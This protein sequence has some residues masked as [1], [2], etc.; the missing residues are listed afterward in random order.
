MIA[1]LLFPAPL[2][3][4]DEGFEI[5]GR[6][7]H[8][9]RDADVRQLAALDDVVDGSRAEAQVRSDF[10]NAEKPVSPTLN[11]PEPERARSEPSLTF[12][13]LVCANFGRYGRLWLDST[14]SGNEP[15]PNGL[16]HLA[17]QRSRWTLFVRSF[18]PWVVGSSPT[19][20]TL[21]A[22]GVT[23]DF[24]GLRRGGLRLR[25]PG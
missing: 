10:S 15:S 14:A 17:M 23:G 21:Q 2:R 6:D 1:H 9:V 13:C 5:R 25:E 4:L 22:D 18:K 20:L 16:N 24:G 11:E 8:R 12:L 3:V 7:P 19:R